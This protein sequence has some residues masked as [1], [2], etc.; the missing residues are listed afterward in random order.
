MKN[1]RWILTTLLLTACATVTP[2][3]SVTS[4]PTQVAANPYGGQKITNE[5]PRYPT[6]PA[7]TNSVWQQQPATSAPQTQT[8]TQPTAPAQTQSRY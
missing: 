3:I 2:P 5:Q 1:I 8:A 7:N 6:A 4:P